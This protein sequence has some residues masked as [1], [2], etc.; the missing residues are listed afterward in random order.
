MNLRIWTVVGALLGATL[1]APATSAQSSRGLP[2]FTEL[3]E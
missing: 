1:F 3:Y 2:D